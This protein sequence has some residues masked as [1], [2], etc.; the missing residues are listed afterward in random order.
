RVI[1]RL[2]LDQ[3]GPAENLGLQL[4]KLLR[5]DDGDALDVIRVLRQELDLLPPR[6]PLGSG[7]RREVRQDP[8]GPLPPVCDRSFELRKEGVDVFG[9]DA[10]RDLETECFFA[11]FRESLDHAPRLLS[12]R[13][14]SQTVSDPDPGA[15]AG[16][17]ARATS[18]ASRSARDA[19]FRSTG[20]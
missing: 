19:V 14:I 20:E 8:D 13:T 1:A 17:A 6:R 7:H 11:A 16:D 5:S 12:T 2:G 3:D 15:D 18:A 4:L 9:R 10:A